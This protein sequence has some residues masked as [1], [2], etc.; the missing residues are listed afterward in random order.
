MKHLL[1]IALTI[2]FGGIAQMQA[3]WVNV[4][5][6]AIANVR[7]LEAV[8]KNVAYVLSENPDERLQKTT[9]RGQQ[10]TALNLPDW[11]STDVMYWSGLFFTDANH[12]FIYGNWLVN[13]GV[14][15]GG[16]ESF[17]VFST[18]DGGQTWLDRTP[19]VPDNGL[20]SLNTFHFFNPQQGFVTYITGLGYTLVMTTDNGGASWEV[21]DTL[22][23]L[24]SSMHLNDDGSGIAVQHRDHPAGSEYAVY[25][26]S[27]FGKQWDFI[28]APESDPDWSQH[29][30]GLFH[31]GYYYLN[32]DVV[33]RWRQDP[34]GTGN[35]D[36]I[37]YIDL[38]R[39]GGQTWQEGFFSVTG[40]YANQFEP[41]QDAIWLSTW[42]DVLRTDFSAVSTQ[43]PD[44]TKKPTLTVVPSPAIAGQISTLVLSDDVY[45]E[46]PARLFASDGR[47]VQ[48][49]TLHF[50]HG[51]GHW[52]V[53][54]QLAPGVYFVE[55]QL[56]GKKASVR[57]L[58]GG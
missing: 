1:L 12:G 28:G 16:S 6:P 14:F 52:R 57:L 15:M 39:N 11:N 31:D 40:K 37:Q 27:D 36:D 4:T 7:Y 18:Q 46:L 44:L 56:E 2:L 34:Q 53:P 49:F 10:W 51:K 25:R 50:N 58:V 29:R 9:D 54:D 35:Q 43:Q 21:Q 41:F 30:I 22:P 3:Q 47:L 42:N 13:G 20:Q 8:D 23:Y 45:A 5:P 55:V 33:F 38:S 19:Q 32:N 17:T 24:N 48:D 26:I